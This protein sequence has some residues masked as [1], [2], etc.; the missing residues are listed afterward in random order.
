MLKYVM[1]T[2][3]RI[4]QMSD[5]ERIEF[6]IRRLG[7]NATEFST[8]TGISGATL[9]HIMSGRSLPTLKIF[10]AIIAAYPELN[11]EWMMMGTGTMY[12]N[13]ESRVQNPGLEGSASQEPRGENLD[14]GSDSMDLFS[15]AEG[16]FDF[17]TESTKPAKTAASVQ[18]L[19]PQMA[20]IQPGLSVED[21]VMSTVSAMNNFKQRKIVEVRIFFDDGTFQEFN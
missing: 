16:V 9:S 4:M 21:V 18:Q 5:K 1:E 6:L 15:G 14:H 13:Q 11:P 10:R 3:E 17:P 12:K 7:I 8:K 19:K 2:N 20:S